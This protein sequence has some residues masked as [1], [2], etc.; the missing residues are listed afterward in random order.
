[1]EKKV[2]A[3]NEPRKTATPNQDT[4]RAPQDALQREADFKRREEEQTGAV[5]G[6]IKSS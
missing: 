2:A 6:E 3:K 5:P 1:M 4:E